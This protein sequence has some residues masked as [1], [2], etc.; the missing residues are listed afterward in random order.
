MALFGI[1]QNMFIHVDCSKNKHTWLYLPRGGGDHVL[2][3]LCTSSV[4]VFF[5]CFVR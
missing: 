2:V 3:L 5:P 4:F 1:A